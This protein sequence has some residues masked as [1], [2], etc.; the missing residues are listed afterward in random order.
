MRR[1]REMIRENAVLRFWLIQ[2]GTFL[3]ALCICW[4]GFWKALAT[5]R[6]S[7]LN[8][9]QHLLRQGI[10]QVEDTLT[11]MYHLG[12]QIAYSDAIDALAKTTPS[13]STAYN[14]AM[15]GALKECVTSGTF[16]TPE[17]TQKY[18]VYISSVDRILYNGDAYAQEVFRQYLNG[19]GVDEP[20]WLTDTI[21]QST[22]PWF[23]TTGSGSSFYIFPIMDS[24]QERLSGA[25]LFRL[26]DSFLM[27]KMPFLADFSSFSLMVYE[28]NGQSP[29]FITD[30]LGCLNQ[31]DPSWRTESGAHSLDHKLV[32]SAESDSALRQYLLI[33]PESEAM[34][35]LRHWQVLVICL[36]TCAFVLEA[37]LFSVLFP[38]RQ[39]HQSDCPRPFRGS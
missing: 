12:M 35:A 4:G 3:L 1:L 37:L 29:F 15:Q 39:A 5:V 7:T 19:W 17:L 31:I 34:E 27:T 32:L 25:V 21:S 16:Y 11:N 10:V 23:C 33:I 38:H 20:D 8:E 24:F 2:M 14:R 28:R 30:H 36:L 13:R 9:N 26:D 18:F 22:F 6:Q